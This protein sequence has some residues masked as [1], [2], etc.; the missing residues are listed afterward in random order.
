MP[1]LPHLTRPGPARPASLGTRGA[2]ALGVL[3]LVGCSS[4]PEIEGTPPPAERAA[5]AA[6][7]DALP[8]SVGGLERRDVEPAGAA[9][10]AWGDPA[11]MLSC[12]VSSP[13]GLSRTSPC[14]EV[15]GIGWYLPDDAVQDLGDGDD[16]PQ[17][18]GNVT[19]TT[20]G[21]E[22]LVSV[23]VPADHRPPAGV[24]ADLASPLRAGLVSVAPCR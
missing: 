20:I 10:A 15:D 4:T 18:A 8:G 11:V 7:V 14:L 2:L 24:L 13:P 3:A 5:C 19:L 16:A 21:T 17:S 23:A 6:L 22:P 1:G 12:G 9:G